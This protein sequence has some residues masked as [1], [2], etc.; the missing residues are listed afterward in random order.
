MVLISVLVIKLSYKPIVFCHF[1]F[2]LIGTCDLIM[3]TILSI[4]LMHATH[5]FTNRRPRDVEGE[6]NSASLQ[7]YLIADHSDDD[8]LVVSA[9]PAQDVGALLVALLTQLVD[10]ILRTR[11]GEKHNKWRQ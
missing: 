11:G 5:I 6:L 2:I 3:L 10:G 1:Q 7:T 9:A 4:L 8:V